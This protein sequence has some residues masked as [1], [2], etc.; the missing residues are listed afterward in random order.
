M[1]KV[2]SQNMPKYMSASSRLSGLRQLSAVV[3]LSMQPIRDS[4]AAAATFHAVMHA[5]L[6]ERVGGLEAE[7]EWSHVLSSDL[8]CATLAT[9]MLSLEERRL[10]PWSCACRA[11][12]PSGWPGGR[13][14]V[15][16]CAEARTGA[17]QHWPQAC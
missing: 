2:L 5:E 9:G 11:G 7:A 16:P 10:Q 14:G 8:C 3:V 4:T 13:G 17:V 15:D 6:V 1:D 12:G